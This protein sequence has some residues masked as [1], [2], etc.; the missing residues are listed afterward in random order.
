[1]TPIETLRKR[2]KEY[3]DNADE[4]SLRRVNAI[5]EID[6]NANGWW[7]D[8]QFV[9]ELD[10]RYNDIESGK[11]KGYTPD[12]LLASVREHKKNKDAG[13]A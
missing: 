7:K 10:K 8:K 1:M 4:N 13:K 3:I 9:A 6:N 2:A 12:E 11:D 5:L